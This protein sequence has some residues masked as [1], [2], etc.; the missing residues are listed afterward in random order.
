VLTGHNQEEYKC[1]NTILAD[2]ATWCLDKMGR[3]CN[4]AAYGITGTYSD[5]IQEV[6]EQNATGH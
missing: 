4:D 3:S 6:E 1:S 5:R 2:A